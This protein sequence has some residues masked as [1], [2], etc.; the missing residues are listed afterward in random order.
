MEDAGQLPLPPIPAMPAYGLAAAVSAAAAGGGSGAVCTP[1]CS[2][3]LGTGLAPVSE[4]RAWMLTKTGSGTWRD[5]GPFIQASR[6]LDD[7][8]EG[9]GAKDRARQRSVSGGAATGPAG[10]SGRVGTGSRG[11]V[12][13]AEDILLAGRA[14]WPGSVKS[15]ASA[16]APALNGPARAA[17]PDGGGKASGGLAGGRVGGASGPSQPAG[18]APAG[19]APPAADGGGGKGRSGSRAQVEELLVR[20]REGIAIALG[21]E[22]DEVA[23]LCLCLSVSLSFKQ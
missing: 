22:E 20:M 15:A 21:V 8:D 14:L 18:A 17:G 5:F 6:S 7:E 4:A 1:V 13:A 3:P 12:C 23:S 2:G 19:A 10:G 16:H 11:G 9:D